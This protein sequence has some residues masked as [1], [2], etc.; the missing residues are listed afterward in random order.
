L[1]LIPGIDVTSVRIRNVEGASWWLDAEAET[2]A[3]R[4]ALTPLLIGRLEVLILRV[5]GGSVR[6]ALSTADDPKEP[7]TFDI[8]GLLDAL[9]VATRL[10]NVSLVQGRDSDAGRPLEVG[11]LTL[12]RCGR[13]VVFEGR[14][15]DTPLSIDARLECEGPRHLRLPGSLEPCA[16]LASTRPPSEPGT[17]TR[18]L[19]T[20][21]RSMPGSTARSP[22]HCSTR[23]ISI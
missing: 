1:S 23:W 16:R 5:D 10:E 6:F 20:P 12:R 21:V 8:A 11:K 22:T 17:G 2:L 15:G 19:R 7:S 13:P 18:S 3:L 4:I 9:P 14:L